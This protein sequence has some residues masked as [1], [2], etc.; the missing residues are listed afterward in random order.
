[1]IT[2]LTGGL[3]VLLGFGGCAYLGVQGMIDEQR[4]GGVPIVPLLLLSVPLLVV[5]WLAVRVGRL[6]IGRWQHDYLNRTLRERRIAGLAA[7]LLS[8]GLLYSAVGLVVPSQHPGHHLTAALKPACGGSAV[9]GAGGAHRAG[10]ASAHLVVLGA[11]G[12]EQGWTGHAPMEWKPASLA[13]T[14]LVACVSAHDA[15]ALIETCHYTIGPALK[16][17]SA[18]RHVKLIEPGSGR[19]VA[20]YDVTDVPPTCPP[21]KKVEATMLMGRVEWPMVQARLAAYAGCCAPAPTASP[22]R[23]GEQPQVTP[24]FTAPPMPSPAEPMSTIPP[25]PTAPAEQPAPVQPETPVP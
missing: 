16:R 7:A 24:R 4:A 10:A 18:T 22:G 12:N 5:G 20:E 23:H 21:M 9:A 1:M 13:D 19:V 17:Y 2:R 15:D 25:M 11:D 8:G 3:V 6:F 14:E